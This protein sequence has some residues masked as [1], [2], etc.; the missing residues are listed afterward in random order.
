MLSIRDLASNAT[1]SVRAGGAGW[2]F[3]STG[4]SVIGEAPLVLVQNNGRVL[5]IVDGDDG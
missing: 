4:E 3:V 1:A 2:G 5:A